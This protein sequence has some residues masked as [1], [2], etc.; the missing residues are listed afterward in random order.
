MPKIKLIQHTT[1]FIQRKSILRKKIKATTK[2]K[3][4]RRIIR[5][6]V[7]IRNRKNR[8]K[9]PLPKKPIE[10]K[11]KIGIQ[12]ILDDLCK[13]NLLMIEHYD[14]LLDI[15]E[16]P[17]FDA[18][19]KQFFKPNSWAR[20]R[21]FLPTTEFRSFALNLNFYSP[22]GYKHV[23]KSYDTYLPDS[24][25]VGQWY[26][27]SNLLPGFTAEAFERLEMAAKESKKLRKQ[28][29]VNLICGEIPLFR[30]WWNDDTGF[31]DIGD[32]LE[33]DVKASDAFVFIVAGIN[34]TWKLPVG[35]F[36][37]HSVTAEQTQNLISL[38]IENLLSTGIKIVGISIDTLTNMSTCRLL[39]CDLDVKKSEFC[40]KTMQP[41]GKICIVPNLCHNLNRIKEILMYQSPLINQSGNEI[42]WKYMV[43]LEKLQE[44]TKFHKYFCKENINVKLAVQTM[45]KSVADAM[46]Y[47]RDVSFF[48]LK[49]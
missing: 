46:D 11:K 30:K 43:A 39:G 5:K 35:Y 29:Y 14:I 37:I 31:I 16:P 41:N 24:S 26:K 22:K 7:P 21:V 1:E 42:N 49:P 12:E 8:K 20:G 38:C 44:S 23:R 4:K 6:N 47:C 2:Y 10:V 27:N 28:I 40:F 9:I 45:G 19:E 13:R 17:N 25:T 33:N 32:Q 3:T 15:C 34:E 36:L 18:F 48:H